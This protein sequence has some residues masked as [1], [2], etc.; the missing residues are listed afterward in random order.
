M[1]ESLARN[2]SSTIFAS[3]AVSVFLA[4]RFRCAQAAASSAEF[5]AAIC[6]IRLSRRLADSCTP[7]TDLAYWP[8][9]GDPFPRRM[10][11]NGRQAEKAG[12]LIDARCLDRRDFMPAKAF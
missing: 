8:F 3:A 1:A 7:R 5:I 9:R 4:G 12:F 10:R 11:K 2:R 6:S